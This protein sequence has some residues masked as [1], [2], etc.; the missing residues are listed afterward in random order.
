MVVY[1]VKLLVEIIMQRSILI[2][3]VH[4]YMYMCNWITLLHS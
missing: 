1:V 2:K 3:S 4:C